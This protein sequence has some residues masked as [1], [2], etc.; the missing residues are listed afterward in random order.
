MNCNMCCGCGGRAARAP[1]ALPAVYELM[2]GDKAVSTVTK[3][4]MRGLLN[5]SIKRNLTI[6]LTLAAITGVAFKQLVGNERKK[7]YAEFYRNYDAEKEFE[8][9]KKKGLFQSC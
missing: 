4:Q 8:E 1:A 3:P 7:R 2:A 5:S 6:S 9:M